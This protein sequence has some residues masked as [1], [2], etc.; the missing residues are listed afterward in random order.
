MR[1]VIAILLFAA[2]AAAQEPEVVWEKDWKT[3]FEKA[4][5]QHKPVFVDYS[6]TWCQPCQIMDKTVLPLPEVREKLA[7]FILLKITI[8]GQSSTV[9]REQNVR[10][11]PTY[12]LLDPAGRERFRQIG[13]GL[14][15]PF[16]TWLAAAKE[17]MAPMMTAALLFERNEEIGGW[18]V[19]GQTYRRVKQFNQARD[20]F[21]QAR[22]AASRAGKPKNVQSAEIALAATTALEGKPKRAIDT[23]AAITEKPVDDENAATA[24]LY[25]G[26]AQ[27]LLKNDTAARDAFTKAKSLAPAGSDIAAQAATA[28]ATHK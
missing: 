26:L 13:G 23:L 5:Q 6:A 25:I 18:M 21:E 27:E 4:A 9:T 20:A 17:A 19:V 28:L 22:R 1:R 12:A 10:V 11:F 2:A 3:A 8:S 16:V 15:G 24:W 14:P 7:G